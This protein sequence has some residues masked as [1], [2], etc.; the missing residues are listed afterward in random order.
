MTNY[1]SSPSHVRGDLFT[2]SGKWKYTVVI[3]MEGVYDCPLLHEA[4]VDALRD[5]P[6]SFRGVVDGAVGSQSEYILVVLNPCH[7]NGYPVMIRLSDYP[8]GKR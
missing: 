2:D 5:T 1:S 6:S 3:D 8:G 4:I 7:R